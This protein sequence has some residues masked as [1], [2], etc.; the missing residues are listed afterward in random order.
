MNTRGRR[1]LG[2][3]VEWHQPWPAVAPL[4]L[5]P[6]DLRQPPQ[7]SIGQ[8]QF[9]QLRD[10]SQNEMQGTNK[11]QDDPTGGSTSLDAPP[12]YPFQAFWNLRDDE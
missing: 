5:R 1:F 2:P 4:Q 3:L 11:Q 6:G 7:H 10:A 8:N 12:A 9:E